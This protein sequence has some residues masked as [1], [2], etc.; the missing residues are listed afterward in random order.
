MSPFCPLLSAHLQGKICIFVYAQV[1]KSF[2][3]G[4]LVYL[5]MS[6][7]LMW[8]WYIYLYLMGKWNSLVKFKRSASV[9]F[10]STNQTGCIPSGLTN[11]L[12]YRLPH[13]ILCHNF[14]LEAKNIPLS[15]RKK[16]TNQQ[17]SSW[18]RDYRAL[19]LFTITTAPFNCIRLLMKKHKS[20]I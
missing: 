20:V 5:W 16:P 11:W 9:F 4:E 6:F 15:D 7:R 13:S 1:Y 19:I 8:V 12:I 17:T 18:A 3:I 14:H 10:K 2:L